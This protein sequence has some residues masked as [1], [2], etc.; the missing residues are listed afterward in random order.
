MFAKLILTNQQS[1][2]ATIAQRGAT[3]VNMLDLVRTLVV[4]ARGGRG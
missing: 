2:I 4:G 3:S 1:E